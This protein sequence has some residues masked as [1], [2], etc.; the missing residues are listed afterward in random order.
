MKK[1]TLIFRKN[2][3]ERVGKGTD[4]KSLS[5]ESSSSK[6]GF[7]KILKIRLLKNELHEGF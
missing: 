5:L 3:R 6:S 2:G 7:L 1:I 4:S